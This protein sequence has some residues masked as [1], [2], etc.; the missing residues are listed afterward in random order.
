MAAATDQRWVV[1]AAA[2]CVPGTAYD[3]ERSHA[4]ERSP[5]N[6]ARR[7]SPCH[8][9]R[10]ARPRSQTYA[11]LR[12]HG[13][14]TAGAS[15]CHRYAAR[16]ATGSRHGAACAAR[17]WRRN[18]GGV[19]ALTLLLRQ[20]T[21]LG[22]PALACRPGIGVHEQLAVGLFACGA[23]PI[24]EAA[25]LAVA[26]EAAARRVLRDARRV[27]VADWHVARIASVR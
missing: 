21:A 24:G 27:L 12:A 3:F 14:R 2:A 25:A 22:A 8:R 6:R 23:Q 13:R 1:A 7:R 4:R 16:K 26:R 18:S 11:N 19:V 15:R 17:R 10:T 20:C 9:S 5:A